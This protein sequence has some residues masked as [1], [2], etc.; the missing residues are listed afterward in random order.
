MTNT[1]HKALNQAQSQIFQG[2]S[3]TE[4]KCEHN[5]WGVCVCMLYTDCSLKK[6]IFVEGYDLIGWLACL[7][8]KA[9][10][11]LKEDQLLDENPNLF[12]GK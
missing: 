8:G 7:L 2:H 12:N 4:E 9:V 5:K 6:I 10:L 11:P 3:H 1:K